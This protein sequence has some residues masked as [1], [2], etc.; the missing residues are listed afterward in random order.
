MLANNYLMLFKGKRRRNELGNK[1]S[2]VQENAVCTFKAADDSDE[3][4]DPIKRNLFEHVQAYKS[5]H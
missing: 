4:S 1:K 3:Y 2:A 5:Q